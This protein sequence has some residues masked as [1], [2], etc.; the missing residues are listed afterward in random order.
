MAPF[1]EQLMLQLSLVECAR[2]AVCRSVKSWKGHWS[3]RCSC[4]RIKIFSYDMDQIIMEL[5]E[6][7]IVL[8]VQ[9]L[10]SS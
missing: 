1:Q 10:A 6:A 7:M 5:H 2:R 9:A 4:I 3:M 8:S